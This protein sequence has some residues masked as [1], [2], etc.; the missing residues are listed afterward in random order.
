MNYAKQDVIR[1][2]IESLVQ[3]LDEDNNKSIETDKL[4][5]LLRPTTNTV[6]DHANAVRHRIR[7]TILNHPNNTNDGSILLTQFDKNQEH[8]KKLN[9]TIV[10]PFLAFLSPLAFTEK[11]EVTF[12]NVLKQDKLIDK[13]LHSATSENY[14]TNSIL[15]LNND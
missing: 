14:K 1:S 4:L 6:N 11:A 12:K 15:L 2:K 9:P 8:L 13:N 10:N 7:N 5:R 3:L